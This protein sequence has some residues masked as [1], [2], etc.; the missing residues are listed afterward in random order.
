MADGRRVRTEYKTYNTELA[1]FPDNMLAPND[2]IYRNEEVR[3]GD[4][5][6]KEGLISRLDI[7][8]GYINMREPSYDKLTGYYFITD[9]LG[10][11]RI[12]CNSTRGEVE[13]N[14]EYLPSGSILKCTESNTVLQPN[15]FCGKE[16]LTMHGYDMYDSKAR[17]LT[18]KCLRFT[19]L[20]PLAEKYYSISP[21]AANN[22]V[23]MID[24]DGRIITLPKGA[25]TK[26]IYLVLG[27]LQKLTNDR[28]VYSTQKDGTIRIKVTS[29]GEGNK[30]AGTN[31][32]RRL[33][34][35]DKTLTIDVQNSQGYF[36]DGVGNKA[37]ATNY[38]NAADGTGSDA[39]VSFDPTSNPS[40]MTKDT[41]TGNVSG[42]TR[43]NQIGLG[44]ELIHAEHYMDGDYSPSTST[45]THTY[46][47][48][49]GNT[50]TQTYKTEELRTVGVA[51]TK[52]D[53]ITEN[54]LRK[55]QKQNSRGAY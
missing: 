31:L 40:I 12:T 27:N 2:P 47:D 24:P 39:I 9:H 54:Q 29:L 30:T 16:E 11:V 37:K 43:P 26:N 53:D 32:I 55:E 8:G 42:K 4:L 38:T 6:I 44:H 7:P 25:S 22:P 20:D 19:S 28:L 14:I 17:F 45:S 48:A 13:Q 52:K 5:L 35:S 23:N 50:V 33:N 10:S 18:S 15:R 1:Y 3:A 51:G 41:K 49:S 46:K 21:Y 34:S 36:A